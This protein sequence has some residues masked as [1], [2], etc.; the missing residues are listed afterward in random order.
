M[1]DYW[2]TRTAN[3]DM[4]KLG[5]NNWCELEVMQSAY[6]WLFLASLSGH[7][8]DVRSWALRWKI[9]LSFPGAL[10]DGDSS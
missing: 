9:G 1:I 10:A 3:F 6:H 5:N 8:F 4:Y 7:S 2:V